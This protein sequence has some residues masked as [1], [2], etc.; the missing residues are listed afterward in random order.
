MDLHAKH[1][2][3]RTRFQELSQTI[4]QAQTEALKIAGKLELIEEWLQQQ[5]TQ[6]NAKAD[7][8]RLDVRSQFPPRPP[9][10]S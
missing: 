2:A 3:L 4:Q 9:G 10:R 1:A 5:A 7:T 8:E 6:T